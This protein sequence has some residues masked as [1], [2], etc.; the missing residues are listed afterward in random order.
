[1][2]SNLQPISHVLFYIQMRSYLLL[3]CQW[4]NRKGWEL[5]QWS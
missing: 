2:N 3:G 5:L 1:M 4:W